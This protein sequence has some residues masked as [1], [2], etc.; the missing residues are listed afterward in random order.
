MSTFFCFFFRF[1]LGGGEFGNFPVLSD[2]LPGA[3]SQAD[4]GG[5][6]GIFAFNRY[7]FANIHSQIS[8]RWTRVNLVMIV[9]TE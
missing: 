5:I 7:F 2:V 8:D 4:D 1:F 9:W 3:L 6:G